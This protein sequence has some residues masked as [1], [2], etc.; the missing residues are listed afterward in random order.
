MEVFTLS[1]M[2][3]MFL[4]KRPET[5]DNVYRY[6]RWL[7]WGQGIESCATGMQ[8]VEAKNLITASSA[9]TSVQGRRAL[10]WTGAQQVRALAAFLRPS[11]TP[12]PGGAQTRM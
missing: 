1:Q 12:N 5:L 3:S 11:Q 4:T 7:S 8:Q 6:F 9:Q 2:E 10:D